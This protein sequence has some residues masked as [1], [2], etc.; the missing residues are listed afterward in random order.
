MKSLKQLPSELE[1]RALTQ[2]VVGYNELAREFG[3]GKVTPENYHSH[4]FCDAFGMMDHEDTERNVPLR[5]ALVYSKVLDRPG[6]GFFG[7][8]AN[9]RGVSISADR[10]DEEWRDELE[11]LQQYYRRNQSQ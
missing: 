2:D 11:Q 1:R 5:A 9:R 3:L 7:A 6:N 8:I 4:P 10:Q